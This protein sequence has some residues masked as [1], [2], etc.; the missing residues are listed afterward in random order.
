MPFV[1]ADQ[2]F[3]AYTLLFYHTKPAQLKCQ[4]P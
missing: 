2:A 1:R 3:L 4:Q